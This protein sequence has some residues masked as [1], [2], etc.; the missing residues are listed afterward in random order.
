ME[1]VD[2]TQQDHTNV[3]LGP[4]A[5]AAILFGAIA[6][7]IGF[8]IVADYRSGSQFRHVAIEGLVMALAI[9]GVAT[10][11][12]RFRIASQRATE[13][14]VDIEAARREAQRYRV[15]A[16]EALKGLGEAIEKQFIRWGLTTAEREV[17]LLLLKGLSHKEISMIRSTTETTIRQQALGVYRKSGVHSRTELSAYFLE[18]LLLPVQER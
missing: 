5:L 10:L 13:L 6:V 1:N 17:G 2:I 15:E 16:A 4:T 3:G 11:W 7:L 8:D 12:R 14:T 9:A 18:D